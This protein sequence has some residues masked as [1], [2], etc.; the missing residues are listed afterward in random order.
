MYLFNSLKLK[1]K[2][3]GGQKRR[4]RSDSRD[5]KIKMDI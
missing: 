1:L 4:K 5:G 2:K 3:E